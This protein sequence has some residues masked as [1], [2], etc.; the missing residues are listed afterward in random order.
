M[1]YLNNGDIPI[2]KKVVGENVDWQLSNGDCTTERNCGFL[3][4]MV[5]NQLSK[6]VNDAS[7]I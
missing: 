3:I 4:L 6:L 1:Q 5:N 7:S 2:S